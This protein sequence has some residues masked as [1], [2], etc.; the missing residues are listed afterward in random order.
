MKLMNSNKNKLNSKNSQLFKPIPN[1]TLFG[2]Q[3]AQ[4]FQ[5]KGKLHFTIL[6]YTLYYT[7]HSKLSKCTVR[8]STSRNSNSTLFYHP[9]KSLY[10]YTILFYNTSHIPSFYFP[11]LLIKIIY[12]H[13]K[14]YFSFF[15]FFQFPPPPSLNLYHRASTAQ[16]PPLC[17]NHAHHATTAHCPPKSHRNKNPY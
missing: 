12:L 6:K 10:H 13:N 14:I 11:I 7:L 9:K 16:S 8:A 5:F 4:S 17:L 1:T 2:Q 3:L 15:V